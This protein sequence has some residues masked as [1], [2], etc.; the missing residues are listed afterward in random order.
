MSIPVRV[1]FAPS[2]TGLLHVGGVRTALYNWLYARRRSGVMV[3]RIDDTDEAREDPED[4][5]Q[6][7]RALRWCVLEGEE[8]PGGGGLREPSLQ[9]ERRPL[10]LAAVAKML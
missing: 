10:H 8:G 2:P 3:L 4:I 5:E 7:Q 9:S 1:R 6:I